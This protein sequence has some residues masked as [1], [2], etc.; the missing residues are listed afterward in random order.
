ME[1]G[2][3][4]NAIKDFTKAIALEPDFAD[5]YLKRGQVYHDKRDYKRAVLDF[6]KLVELKPD[7]AHAYVLRGRAYTNSA[8]LYCISSVE[9][10]WE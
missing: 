9:Q 8:R 5:A 10:I 1:E 7:D 3:L 4:D 2:D 6:T